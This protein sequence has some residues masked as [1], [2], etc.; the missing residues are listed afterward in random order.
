MGEGCTGAPAE[1]GKKDDEG[2]GDSKDEEPDAASRRLPR[3]PEGLMAK[4]APIHY[5]DGLL[6]T[7]KR[8]TFLG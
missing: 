6:V 8:V 3:Q 7:Q 4:G 5:L 2:P 1:G